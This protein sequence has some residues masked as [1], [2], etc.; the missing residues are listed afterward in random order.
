MEETLA[1]KA[2]NMLSD[3]KE[4]YVTVRIKGDKSVLS[5]L[6][7]EGRS[8]EELL[9]DDGEAN[10][11]NQFRR[12]HTARAAIHARKAGETFVKRFGLHQ[13][14]DVAGFH[15]V[16]KLMRMVFHLII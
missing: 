11:L 6:F 10:R 12:L 15:H 2:E 16:H 7:I 14:L 13:R 4:A 3:E 1:P 9:T 8:V 5:G